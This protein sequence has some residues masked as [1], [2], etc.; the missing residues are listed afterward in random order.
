MTNECGRG[1]V[2]RASGITDAKKKDVI[3]KVTTDDGMVD[4]FT[5]RFRVCVCVCV[6][7]CSSC[8]CAPHYAIPASC[9]GRGL[10]VL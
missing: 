9:S 3:E 1:I 10:P 2:W 5:D 6:C 4:K 8:E 7:A